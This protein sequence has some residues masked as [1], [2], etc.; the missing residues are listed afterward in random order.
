MTAHHCLD[1]VDDKRATSDSEKIRM[2]RSVQ[3]AHNNSTCTQCSR[4]LCFLPVL[5]ICSCTTSMQ[6]LYSNHRRQISEVTSCMFYSQRFPFPSLSS[7]ERRWEKAGWEIMRKSNISYRKVSFLFPFRWCHD[8]SKRKPVQY[9]WPRQRWR[10]RRITVLLAIR[11]LG[12]TRIIVTLR[13]L[14]LVHIISVQEQTSMVLSTAT[15]MVRGLFGLLWYTNAVWVKPRWEYDQF[16]RIYRKC[17]HVLITN[18]SY[19]NLCEKKKRPPLI[20]QLNMKLT[21]YTRNFPKQKNVNLFKN[22]IENLFNCAYHHAVDHRGAWWYSH[23]LYSPG[24]F[25][26]TD[27]ICSRANLNGRITHNNRQGTFWSTLSTNTCNMGETKMRI[28]PIQ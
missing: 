13:L 18:Q 22:N 3:T 9:I 27:Y 14:S 12:G 8:R 23:Y 10:R 26:C 15:I 1:T 28:R 11:V 19:H 24:S 20:K 4:L 21:E 5:L 25:S 16:N 2:A 7:I 17:A 6:I